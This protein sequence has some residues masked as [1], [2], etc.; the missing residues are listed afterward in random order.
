MALGTA[1]PAKFNEAI[2]RALGRPAPMPAPLQALF[3]I[4]ER[5]V[6][7]ANDVAA[8]KELIDARLQDKIA[9]A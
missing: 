1:H 6:T 8:V 4:E 3:D 5:F 7:L 2:E 9:A